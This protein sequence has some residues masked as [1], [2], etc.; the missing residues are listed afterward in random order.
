MRWSVPAKMVHWS[1][2][3]S[4]RCRVC[5][6]S[7]ETALWLWA[8][9]ADKREGSGEAN[10]T[11]PSSANSCM[12]GRRSSAEITAS[13]SRVGSP[14]TWIGARARKSPSRPSS[15]CRI[16]QSCALN[17]RLSP[18]SANVSIESGCCCC[19]W[20]ADDC[21]CCR[22]GS[23]AVEALPDDGCVA[24]VRSGS[25]LRR[26]IVPVLLVTGCCCS[27]GRRLTLS[28][29]LGAVSVASVLSAR[30]AGRMLGCDCSR[31]WVMGSAC[32][33]AVRTACRILSVAELGFLPLDPS[34][35]QCQLQ[36]WSR[37]SRHTEATE[38]FFRL[39]VPNS[40]ASAAISAVGGF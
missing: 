30:R 27:S 21:I 7:D 32:C 15:G 16:C 31:S 10:T 40:V 20:A 28:T 26:F 4:S 9:D 33:R 14:T 8:A 1:S 38:G 39:T 24:A 12:T 37:D 22:R 17:S 29:V 3:E 18:G 11:A 36:S 34:K 6:A 5:I 13:A 23:R 2:M 35:S 25:V 19:C